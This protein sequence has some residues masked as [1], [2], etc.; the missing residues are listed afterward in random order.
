MTAIDA[1]HRISQWFDQLAQT[2]QCMKRQD[3]CFLMV[4][5]RHLIEAAGKPSDSRI[6][7]FYADWVVHT[8]LD[9]STVCFETLKNLTSELAKNFKPTSPTLTS[10][11]SSVIGFPRLRAE[12]TQLFACS[13]LPTVVFDSFTNWQGFL[14][15]L[16]WL[17]SGQPV[18]FPKDAKG[19]AKKLRDEIL[20]TNRPHDILV[21]SIAVEYFDDAYH[22]KLRVSGQKGITIIGRIDPGE[23]Q[24][25]FSSP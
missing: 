20:A 23:P 11:I 16:L 1:R 19:S 22:W 18:Q 3:V 6:V 9:R 14:S 5:T 8:S 7:A 4:Q 24:A 21:E 15:F 13:G 17:I 25:N 12:L 2:D 10:Q